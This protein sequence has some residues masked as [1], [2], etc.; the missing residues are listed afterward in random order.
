MNWLRINWGIKYAKAAGYNPKAM[1]E[2]LE[3]LKKFLA[4]EPLHPYS[5]FWRSHPYLDDRIKHA[6]LV[7]TGQMTFD[8]YINEAAQR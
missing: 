2:F 3:K 6:R 1:I 7:I 5:Y 8:D 4:S